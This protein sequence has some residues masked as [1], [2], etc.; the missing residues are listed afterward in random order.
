VHCPSSNLKLGSG[1]APV[2]DLL[3]RGVS[4]SLAAD[5]APCNNN[6]DIFTEM[7]HA[8]LM[9]R[10]PPR[11][12]FLPPRRL[13]EMATIHGARALGL[14]DRIGSIEEGKEADLAVLDLE[15]AHIAPDSDVYSALVFAARASDV[16]A[17]IVKGEVLVERGKHVRLDEES[18]VAEG[19]RQAKRV[20]K[21]AGLAS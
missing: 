19:R 2:P 21:R 12:R 8:G 5:G 4:V 11:P 3:A 7:R 9:Q 17:T 13:V 15:Q 6:L 18:I 20:Q 16:V 14:A 10:L 1:V